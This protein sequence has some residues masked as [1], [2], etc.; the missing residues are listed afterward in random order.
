M[1]QTALILVG[2]GSHL[3]SHAAGVVWENVDALRG[4]GVAD[5]VTAAFWKEQ[6]SLHH[7]LRT[8]RADDVTIVP[9]STT[10]GYFTQTVIPSEMGLASQPK[11]H[12]RV[13]S[14]LNEHPAFTEIV[15]RRVVAAIHDAEAD[16][17]ETAVVLIGHSGRPQIESRLATEAQ[18]EHLRR[19]GVAAEVWTVYLDGTLQIAD[20]Y[21]MSHQPSLI[22]VPYFL[23]TGLHT[24]FDVP[25]ALGL[26]IGQTAGIVAGRRVFYTLPLGGENE[27]CHVILEVAQ[28]A[29]MPKRA[30]SP[31][32]HGAWAGF[33]QMGRDTLQEAWLSGDLQRFGQ[34]ELRENR[35]QVWGDRFAEQAIYHPAELRQWIRHAPF[36]TTEANLR[37][38]W[39]VPIEDV[40]TLGGVIETVY[41]GV[42]ASWAAAQNGE[43]FIDSFASTIQRQTGIYR[44]LEGL[45]HER[46]AQMVAQVCERCVCHPQWF[47]E[48]LPLGMLACP[49]VCNHWLSEAVE[50]L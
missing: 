47:D 38:G 22:A 33:P 8:I 50:E 46:Q 40:E 32:K 10:H 12:L 14:P 17:Q 6:P 39:Y 5:E 42:V 36:L 15:R 13:G 29:G 24:E 28:G 4:A 27:L 49:E 44:R 26:K 9:T 3:N 43:P 35:V 21:E 34:L 41:P 37:P 11:R 48:N 7:V 25:H 18:A 45:S 16:P 30:L 19:V 1:T 2:H 31:V 23:A 20:I